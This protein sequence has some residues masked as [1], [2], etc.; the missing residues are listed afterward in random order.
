APPRAAAPGTGA[1]PLAGESEADAA[2]QAGRADAWRRMWG[3]PEEGGTA[4]DGDQK[5]TEEDR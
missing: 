3:F 4:P 2:A 1:A 5:R